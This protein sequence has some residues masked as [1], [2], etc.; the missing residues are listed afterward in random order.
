MLYF[1]FFLPILVSW[2][3]YIHVFLIFNQVFDRA[4]KLQ[5]NSAEIVDSREG[6]QT[7]FYGKLTKW[8]FFSQLRIFLAILGKYK[9]TFYM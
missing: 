6:L 9:M 5:Q 1:Y 8:T 7:T 2:K 3:F 4:I